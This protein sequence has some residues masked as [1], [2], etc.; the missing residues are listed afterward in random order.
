MA[1]CK[2]PVSGSSVVNSSP[3]S[4]SLRHTFVNLFATVSENER[5][6][7]NKLRYYVCFLPVHAH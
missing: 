1:D 2:K 3:G 7:L 4:C 5:F 6:L